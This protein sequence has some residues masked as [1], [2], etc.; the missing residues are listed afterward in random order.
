MK[1]VLDLKTKDLGLSSGST[2]TEVRASHAPLR[3]LICET[4]KE[5]GPLSLLHWVSVKVKSPNTFWEIFGKSSTHEKCF[6]IFMVIF[7]E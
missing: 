6:R 4:R 2:G 5:Q 1:T 7:K 3:N